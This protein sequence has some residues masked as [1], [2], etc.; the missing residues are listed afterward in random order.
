MKGGGVGE[1][2][3]KNNGF[4]GGLPKKNSNKREDRAKFLDKI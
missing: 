1:G 4:R 2:D 3:A